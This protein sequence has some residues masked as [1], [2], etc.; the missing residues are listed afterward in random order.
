MKKIELHLPEGLTGRQ[1]AKFLKRNKMHFITPKKKA[2]QTIV[3]DELQHTLHECILQRK[4]KKGLLT[5]IE[6]S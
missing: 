1:L 3:D 6:K 5:K 4:L 2:E